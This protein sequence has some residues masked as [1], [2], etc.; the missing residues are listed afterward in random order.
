MSVETHV[1]FFARS[2]NPADKSDWQL[3]SEHLSCVGELAARN[4]AHFGAAHLARPMGLLHD[5]GKY[6]NAFQKRLSGEFTKVDHSTWG[7]V[8]AREEYRK[9][10]GLLGWLMAYG[11]AGHHAGPRA[12]AAVENGN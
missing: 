8:I 12:A 4:A 11:I 2:T 3:L 9:D 10:D 5:L 1:K 7:A 6:T